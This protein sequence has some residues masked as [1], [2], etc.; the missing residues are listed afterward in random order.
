ML[1]K[2][3]VIGARLKLRAA[4][5]LLKSNYTVLGIDVRDYLRASRATS[6]CNRSYFGALMRVC[7]KLGRGSKRKAISGKPVMELW[8]STFTMTVASIDDPSAIAPDG[9]KFERINDYPKGSVSADQR[10]DIF[11]VKLCDILFRKY[12]AALLGV[13]G[14]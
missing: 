8:L 2:S 7:V 12:G 9:V 14:C 3:Y 11:A 6:C 10:E 5:T 13:G 4:C 1:A